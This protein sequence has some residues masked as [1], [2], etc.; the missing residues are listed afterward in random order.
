MLDNFLY[1]ISKEPEM[2]EQEVEYY[3]KKFKKSKPT[4]T[5]NELDDYYPSF[6][7]LENDFR[8]D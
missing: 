7:D 1:D 8:R 5:Y 4:Y 2:S 6:N 3:L